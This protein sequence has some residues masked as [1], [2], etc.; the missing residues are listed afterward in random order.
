MVS[1][2]ALSMTSAFG[3]IKNAT[4]ETVKIYGNCGMCEKTIENAGTSK[5]VASV[6]WDKDTK[7]A[8]LTYDATKT[9]KDEILKKIALAGYDS[10][11]FLAP[12]DVYANLH[13]CCQYDREAKVAV[14]DEKMVNMGHSDAINEKTMVH[15]NQKESHLETVYA[16]YFELKDALV[17]TDRKDAASSAKKLTTSLNA[18]KMGELQN[19]VHMVWM[20]VMQDLKSDA[21]KIANTEN[22][23]E[24]RGYF[25]TLSE[26][27]YQLMKVSKT[28]TPTYFQHCPMAN[29]GKGANWLS[30]ENQVKNPYYGSKMMSCGKTIETIETIK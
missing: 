1:I 4:T 9:S 22:I 3:Q 6:D 27:I 14:K 30:K 21:Q 20:K 13:G 25:D 15:K 2:M 28:E 16:A 29:D 12:D 19:D 17:L 7:M 10:D 5:K 26:N 8:T 11:Y 18:V 24:Q 23:Q